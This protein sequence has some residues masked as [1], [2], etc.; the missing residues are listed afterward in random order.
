MTNQDPSSDKTARRNSIIIAVL[1]I[2][3][4]LFMYVSFIIKTAIK[5]P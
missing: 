4:S 1:A 3:V 5:G 2:G